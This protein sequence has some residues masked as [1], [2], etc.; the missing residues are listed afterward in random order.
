MS[1][2]RYLLLIIVLIASMGVVACTEKEQLPL[3]HMAAKS[4]I[5]V[6]IK[7]LIIGGHDV[8]QRDEKYGFTPLHQAVFFGHREIVEFLIA[9][10]ADVNAKNN[11]G[12]TPL[13]LAKGKGHH[14]IAELLVQHGATEK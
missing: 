9:E 3:L 8:N 7:Q 10:G 2:P 14:A 11:A 12:S 1:N 13:Y 6:E 4:G 5:L